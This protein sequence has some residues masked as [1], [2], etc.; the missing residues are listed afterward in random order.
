MCTVVMKHCVLWFQWYQMS[1]SDHV[2]NVLHISS[3]FETFSTNTV[4][5]AFGSAVGQL[6]TLN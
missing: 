4:T 6:Q 2:K 5:L 1:L 3:V